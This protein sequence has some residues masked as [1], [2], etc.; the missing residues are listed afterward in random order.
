MRFEMSGGKWY[1][2]GAEIIATDI[3]GSNGV[4]HIIDSVILPPA[5]MEEM[6]VEKDML[7]EMFTE[8]E[9]RLVQNFDR[10]LQNLL[11]GR[12]NN[13]KNILT[14]R[15]LSTIDIAISTRPLN[16][17]QVRVLEYIKLHITLM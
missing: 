10:A 6:Q 17:S 7:E 14:N 4:I 5:S 12:S 3:I 9:M 13:V 16:E 15:I 8:S 1:I 2:N 11:S